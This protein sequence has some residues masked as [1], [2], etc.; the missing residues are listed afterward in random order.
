METLDKLRRNNQIIKAAIYARF[1]S[2]TQREESIDA[3]IRALKD[4]ADRNNIVIVEEYIDRAKS[5]TTDQRPEFL[6]MI[7]EASCNK[8]NVV[9][10]HKL[11][12]FARNRSDSIGYRMKLKRHNVSLISV[13]EYLDE[14]CPESIILESV[15]EGMAEYYSKNLAREVTKGLKENAYK[16]LHTGGKPPL[17]YNVNAQTKKLEINEH[18]AESIRIIFKRT[19]EGCGYSEIIDELNLKGYKTK[20]GGVFNKNSLNSILVNEKY[21]GVYIYNKSSS[22]DVDGKRNGHKHKDEEDI[23]R[24]N[25][26]VP[27]IISNE[28]FLIIQ[29]K[30]SK[31]KLTKKSSRAIENYLLRGKMFCG[32]CNGAY[33]GSRRVRGDKTHWIAYGCNK[34]YRNHSVECKNKE[35]SKPFIE[36]YVLEKLSEYAF[37]DKYIPFITKEYNKFLRDKNKEF[38]NQLKAYQ[39][40]LK[41]VNKNIDSLVDMLL[42]TQSQVLLDKLNSLEK[43]KIQIE[44]KIET[45]FN[46]TKQIDITEDSMAKVF[47]KIRDM[48]SSGNI[49]NIKQVIDTYISKIIVYPEEVVIQFNFFPSIS[50]ELESKEKNCPLDECIADIQGQFLSI[51]DQ[52][53]ADDIGGERGS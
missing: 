6:R 21:T 15:L 46:D 38:D 37:N 3:Q 51:S 41:E 44:S 34:R 42:K 25:D 19:L 2:D 32:V 39:S 23:I 14:N 35:L 27:P 50:L 52:Q 4:Y 53:N 40:K 31:R 18:E 16:G 13:L 36:G 1:S 22:K 8:F 12:R 28:D 30:L 29:Q 26:A 7:Q 33:V 9:L 45:L 43:E 5:A 48:L 17:G 24:I 20:K 11:D 10:V 47:S 49:N